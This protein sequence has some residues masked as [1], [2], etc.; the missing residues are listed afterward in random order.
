[1]HYSNLAHAE[2]QAA[3]AEQARITAVK[4]AEFKQS[5]QTV[6][7]AHQDTD[8]SV[9]AVDLNDG[10]TTQLGNQQPFTA[11]STGKLLSA[12]AYLHF[13]EQGKLKTTAKVTED[14]RTMVQLSDND[15]WQRIN[16]AITHDR[17]A[18]YADSIGMKNYDPT[19]N[20]MTA[21]DMAT[22]MRQF[23][24]GALLND[25]HRDQIME[26]MKYAN[27]RDAVVSNV[28]AEYDTYHKIGFTG[29]NIH[30][31]VIVTKGSQAMALVVYTD[32]NGSYPNTKR[33]DIFAPIT[34]A[35][36]KAYF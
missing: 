33:Q 22:L 9:V 19:E 34:A 24:T 31:V 4:Q 2:A 1:M 3:A 16:D 26:Y 15:S 14:L 32:G 23:Y 8:I 35:A 18:A 6:L 10:A 30:D 17:L 21:T 13:V 5:V 27:Y 20:T 7:D 36:L 28:P 11:A 12:I 29:G 25:A